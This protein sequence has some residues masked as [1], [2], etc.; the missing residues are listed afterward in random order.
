VLVPG[1]GAWWIALPPRR[2]V[3]DEDSVGEQVRVGG[4]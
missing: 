4:L 3:Y 2:E 1:S